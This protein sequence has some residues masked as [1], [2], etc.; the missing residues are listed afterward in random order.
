MLMLT[1]MLAGLHLQIKFIDIE[2]LL[3][4]T[5]LEILIVVGMTSFELCD[6]FTSSLGWMLFLYSLF[7]IFDITSF[8]FIFVL[9]PEPV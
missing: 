9:V 8:I 2:R 6:M 7:A 5:R 1:Q 3:L 4:I